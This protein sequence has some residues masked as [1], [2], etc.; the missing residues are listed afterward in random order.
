M[1]ILNVERDFSV[2]TSYV[3]ADGAAHSFQR[4]SKVIRKARWNMRTQRVIGN[5]R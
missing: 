4:S 2:N 5:A 1:R 3:D